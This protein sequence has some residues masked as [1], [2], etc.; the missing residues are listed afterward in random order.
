MNKTTLFSI[1]CFILF[2]F[3]TVNSVF[4]Q[5]SIG[6]PS[7]GFSQIC[8]NSTFNNF[9]VSFTFTPPSDLSPTNQ[10]IVELS[11]VNGFFG[12]TPTVL[13][14]TNPGAVTTSPATINFSIPT[15]TAGENYKL[16]I[17]STGPVSSSSNSVAF[18]AYYKIQDSQ[19]TI[20]NFNSTATYCSGGSYVLTIDNP[21]IGTNDSPLKY[22]S[23]TFN[24]YKEPSTTPIATGQTL[25]VTQPGTYYVKTNYGTCTSDSYSNRVTVTEASSSTNTTITSS[26]G[27]PFCPNEGN[28]VL[29]T[30]VGNSYQWYLDNKIISGAKSQTYATNQPGLYSVI[31]NYG[32]CVANASIDLK[33]Y[34]F[35]NSLNVP[36]IN[37]INTDETLAVSVTTS[38][39]NP[40]FQWYLNETLIPNANSSDYLVQTIGDYK[41][42]ISQNTDCINSEEL[43]FTVNSVNNTD[44]VEIPNLISPNGDGFNDTWVIPQQ[45]SSGTD[46]EVLIISSMGEIVLKTNNY[47]NNWP[48]SINNFKNVNPV[49]Y[50]IITTK[51]GEKRKGSVTIIK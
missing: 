47:L 20:N 4:A 50:Y 48:E 2:L 35:S 21:G 15:N 5:F 46:T 32:G 9:S 18:P 45:Y 12:T 28:T 1:L 37:Y 30:A 42:I 19:F 33:T 10:F 31:V 49:F 7:L 11:D 13:A 34:S 40:A 23:L 29:S 14:T 26:L 44:V 36:A 43:T 3:P 16:R 8:A 6:N 41:V 24:W 51:E 38:A 25:T 17:K 27:N 39:T 22:P